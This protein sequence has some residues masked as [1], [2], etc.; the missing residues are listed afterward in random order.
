VAA[1]LLRFFSLGERG[2]GGAADDSSWFGAC[3]LVRRP[4]S[5]CFQV[6]F[7]GKKAR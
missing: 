2:R 6:I 7:G 3:L 1:F 5:I 4:P